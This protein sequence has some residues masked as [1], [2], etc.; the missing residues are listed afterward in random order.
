LDLHGY[1]QNQAFDALGS[2]IVS[3]YQKQY[4]CVLVITG[5]GGQGDKKGVLY[6]QVPKWLNHPKLKPMI[7][8]FSHA[9]AKDGGDGA[10]YILLKKNT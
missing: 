5:K 10:L 9:Q 3:S 1:T 6:T 2:F 7:L 8:M 4:R